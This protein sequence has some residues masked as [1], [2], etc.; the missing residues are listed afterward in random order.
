MKKKTFYKE[1]LSELGEINRK[2][3]CLEA[4]F[5]VISQPELVDSVNYQ[6]M[7]LKL[8]RQYLFFFFLTIY[9]QQ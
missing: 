4:C 1:I 3:Q 5:K 6:L 9:K 7:G 8:R 2:I